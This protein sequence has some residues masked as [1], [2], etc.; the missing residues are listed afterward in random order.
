M[1]KTN[2]LVKT[3]LKTI[4]KKVKEELPEGYGF[5]V[6]TFNFEEEKNNEMMYVSNAN[7]QDIA[8]AMIEWIIKTENTFGNDTGRY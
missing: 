6:L 1:N 5:A 8:K 4:A 7:R 3:K 2:E